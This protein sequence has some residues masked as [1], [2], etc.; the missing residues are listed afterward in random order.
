MLL[1]MCMPRRGCG[2]VAETPRRLARRGGFGELNSLGACGCLWPPAVDL[3]SPGTT[4][5]D[6]AQAQRHLACSSPPN[7]EAEPTAP[8]QTADCV[9]HKHEENA[10]AACAGR[11]TR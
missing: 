1:E 6:T 4:R 10:L 11:S 8:P 2:L 7:A 5:L 9:A 3:T